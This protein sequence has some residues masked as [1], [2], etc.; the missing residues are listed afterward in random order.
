MINQQIFIICIPGTSGLIVIKAELRIFI[1]LVLLSA[2]TGY[3][4]QY[5]VLHM[6]DL[7]LQTR[8]MDRTPRMQT[9]M[10]KRMYL[11][12]AKRIG[13]VGMGEIKRMKLELVN[14]I[15]AVE[16]GK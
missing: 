1:F 11:K 10:G 8:C 9:P 16:I 12:L 15:D 5:Q 6:Q 7:D 3:Y 14:K 2:M 4:V 13:D